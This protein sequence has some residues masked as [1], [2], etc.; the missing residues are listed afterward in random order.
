MYSKTVKG[1]PREG[2]ESHAIV[3]VIDK[4]PLV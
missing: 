1:K 3:D 4:D 2:S